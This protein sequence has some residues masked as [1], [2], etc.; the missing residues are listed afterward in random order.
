VTGRPGAD[1]DQPGGTRFESIRVVVVDDHPMFRL[2]LGALLTSIDGIEVVGDAADADGALALIGERQPDVVI[3]DLDLGETSGVDATAMVAARHPQI[4]VLVVTMFDDDASVLASLR[5]G[6]R[7]YLLKNA[8]PAVVERAVR[9]V[10]QG[11]VLFGP[12]IAER[13][14]RLLQGGRRTPHPFPELTEREAEVLDEVARGHDNTTIARRLHLSPKTVRNHVSNILT[15]LQVQDRAR[16]IVLAR[17]A[18]LGGE[19][20]GA[21]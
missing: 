8:P 3:M 14:L 7:G 9:A 19:D 1:P 20:G 21:G 17:R 5:A 2:G 13:A 4:A 6:A 11:E 10:A 15:K 18:G 16:A 12:D